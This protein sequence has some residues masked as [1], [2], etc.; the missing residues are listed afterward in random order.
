MSKRVLVVEDEEDNRRIVRIC[1]QVLAMK[2]L[3]Q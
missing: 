3:R 2:S 1:S